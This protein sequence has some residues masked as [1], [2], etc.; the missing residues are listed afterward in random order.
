MKKKI[1]TVLVAAMVL[2]ALGS[3]FGLQT[4]QAQET[5]QPEAGIPGARTVTVTG[6]G[7]ARVEPDQAVV[8]VGVQT[9]A[10][11]A[12]DALA[13]NSA[14][15][16]ALVQ[17]LIDAG[18]AEEDISTLSVQLYPRYGQPVDPEGGGQLEIVG[19]TAV[20]F[21]EVR[22]R[23]LNNLGSVLDAAVAG[24]ANIIQ[25]IRF[26]AGDLTGALDEAREEALND[27]RRKAE[28][29]A[30]LVDAQLGPVV[31]I[32]EFSPGPFAFGGAGGGFAVAEGALEAAQMTQVDPGTQSYFVT[33]Q[34]TWA[35]RP[36][37][38]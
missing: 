25:F 8:Q 17:A 6:F 1:W 29:L 38:Q 16:E 21:V 31:N 9:D 26:E 12:Q 28:Q 34:V 33:L 36:L 35:L 22:V 3:G 27:A 10:E 32:T 19:Y 13:Q 37:S 14:Q 4:G 30:A 2:L 18:V 24:G 11:T 15:T 5:E 23:D 20:T 7:E